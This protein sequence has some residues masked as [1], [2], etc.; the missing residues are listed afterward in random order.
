[1]TFEAARR[2]EQRERYGF[3]RR[4]LFVSLLLGF[5]FLASQLLA[6]RELVG[7]KIYLATNPHSSF[8]YLLTGLHALHLFGGLLGLSYLAIRAR[9]ETAASGVSGTGNS[10]DRKRRASVDAIGLYWHFMDGLWVYLFAL[11]FLWR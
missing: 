8:F 7:Q 9:R 11:L 10:R 6:W 2:A 1:V 5:G 4:W 3:Y